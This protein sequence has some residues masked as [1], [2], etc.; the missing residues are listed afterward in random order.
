MLELNKIQKKE[1]PALKAKDK[2]LEGVELTELDAF[3]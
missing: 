1:K 2:G 3:F